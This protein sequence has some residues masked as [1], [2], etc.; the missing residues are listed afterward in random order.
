M[1]TA[2]HNYVNWSD[3][4]EF[5]EQ[6]QTMSTKHTTVVKKLQGKKKTTFPK[7]FVLPDTKKPS[8]MNDGVC[9]NQS[10]F[11]LKFFGKVIETKYVHLT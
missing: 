10:E 4:C 5:C 6:H 8:K 2:Q 1:K 11:S 7:C 9:L 3:V